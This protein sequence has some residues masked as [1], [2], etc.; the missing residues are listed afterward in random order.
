[1]DIELA[2][3]VARMDLDC[4]QR[5]VQP[6]S[7]LLIRQSFRDAL[8]HFEFAFTQRFDQSSLVEP[9]SER[10]LEILQLIAEGLTNRQIADRL[11]LSINTVKAH[12]RNI[13]SKLGVNNR[14]QSVAKARVLGV[15]PRY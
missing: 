11:Y 13:Y 14:T 2:I 1:M 7:N 6:V 4:V 9:L 5:K 15:L 3:D 10:E 12:A 8:E